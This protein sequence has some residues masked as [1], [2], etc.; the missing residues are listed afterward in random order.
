MDEID[1]EVQCIIQE[2]I[3]EVKKED[4]VKGKWHIRR[5][6]EGV[7]W[8][9]ARHLALGAILKIGGAMSEDGAWV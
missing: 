2:V 8:C 1:H 5:S 4:S 6:K 9:D 7:I 3:T